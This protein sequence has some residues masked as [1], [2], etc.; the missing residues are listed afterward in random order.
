MMLEENRIKEYS[1]YFGED[2]AEQLVNTKNVR[3]ILTDMA[4]QTGK[5]SAVVYINAYQEQLQIILVTKDG[6]PIL[7]NIP[8]VNRKKLFQNAMNFTVEI[9]DLRRRNTTSYLP[10]A[11]KLYQSLIAPIAAELEAANIDTILFSM[12]TGFR[13]FPLAALHD[14]EQFLI[15]KYNITTIPSVSLMDSRYRQIQNTKLLGMGASEF[16]DNTPLPAVPVELE[17]ISEKLWQGNS[18]L[19]QEFTMKNLINQRQNYPYPIV[20]LA[21]HAE[22]KSGDISQSYVQFWEQKLR[23]NQVRQLGWNHPAVELLVLSACQ[24]AVGNQQA[25]LGFAGFAVATGVKS[26]LGSLWLVSDEGTLGLMTEFYAHLSNVKI[27]AE[28]LREAQLA[29]LRGE[30][31][32][33]EGKLRGSGSRGEVT[34]PPELANI[35]SK[36]F[37]HPYYWAGFTMVGSPW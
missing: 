33:E 20:H 21:T 35:H 26:V 19:N 27:K 18:F 31:I 25:E 23:L 32:I 10:F 7:K 16:R 29:M 30:V 22:F 37:V 36:S 12:D 1:D 8:T 2:L 11:Q 28:A 13:L 4:N 6:Q 9:T 14:G 5:E 15:E 24:T 17:T 3:D 34:L